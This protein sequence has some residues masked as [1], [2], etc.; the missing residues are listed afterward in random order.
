MRLDDTNDAGGAQ[1]GA[2]PSPSPA[3][4]GPPRGGAFTL[5]E[6]LV[7]I[8]I[9]TLLLT[10]MMPSLG[11]ARE[12]ARRMSCASNLRQLAIGFNMYANCNLERF[13][14]PGVGSLPEDWIYWESSRDANRGRLVPY[15]GGRFAKKLYTCDSDPI[16]RHPGLQRSFRYSYT[17]N[18]MISGWRGDSGWYVKPARTS[19]IKRAGEKILVID[20][21]SETIDDGCWAPDH[22]QDDGRNCLS[23]RHDK[24]E[25]ATA[26]R[27]YVLTADVSRGNTI[28]ADCHYDYTPRWKSLTPGYYDPWK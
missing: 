12:L 1:A 28:M 21:S 2:G 27:T 19:E 11:K 15:S 4:R 22:Y 18:Y 5:I 23:N 14:L 3:R 24:T 13:P 26:N 17:L 8:T 10:M 9:I 6:L 7:V 20:E 25:E 16:V